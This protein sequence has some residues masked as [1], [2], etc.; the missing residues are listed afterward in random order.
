MDIT[1]DLERNQDDALFAKNDGTIS[2]VF[3]ENV[4]EMFIYPWPWKDRTALFHSAFWYKR[5]D[6]HLRE[7]WSAIAA[8]S[9]LIT[10][11]YL[12]SGSLPGQRDGTIYL[13]EWHRWE[14][15]E[16]LDALIEQQRRFV[17]GSSH[18]SRDFDASIESQPFLAADVAILEKEAGWSKE[19]I[20]RFIITRRTANELAGDQV[21]EPIEQMGRLVQSPMRDWLADLTEAFEVPPTEFDIIAANARIWL[22]RL[23]AEGERRHPTRTQFR[24]HYGSLNNDARSLALVQ[25]AANRCAGTDKRVVFVTGDTLVF[26][27]YRRWHSGVTPGSAEYLQPFALRRLVQYAPIFN[28]NDALGDISNTKPLFDLTRQ[29]VEVTL[30]PFNLSQMGPRG[31]RRELVSRGRRVS[32]AEVVR[33]HRSY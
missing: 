8:Q 33:P 1:R 22:L 7:G 10:A 4:F 14:L 20:E 21:L 19:A 3:D 29:A 6:R 12:L 9:S 26:D 25:W 28:M 24:R 23:S 13:T 30:L 32:C 27:A 5:T 17:K 16:R 11:E 2:Y 31:E 18:L 15:R